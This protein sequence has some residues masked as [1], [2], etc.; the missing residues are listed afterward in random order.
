MLK[1]VHGTATDE[2]LFMAFRDENSLIGLEGFY[3]C[4]ILGII[5]LK[6]QQAIQNAACV[7]FN[8]YSLICYSQ[9]ITI[10]L[11]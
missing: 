10:F 11:T 6:I 1:C 3:H 5:T 9:L 8:I 4:C 7:P 2:K